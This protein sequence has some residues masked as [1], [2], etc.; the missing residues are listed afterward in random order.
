MDK[1]IINPDGTL[2]PADLFE[3][4][5]WYEGS[6][7]KFIREGGRRV[8]VTVL[9]NGVRVSTVFLA[10]DH[11]FR[12]TPL[13]F[14]SMAFSPGD[15]LDIACDRYATYAEAVEGHD[16]MVAECEVAPG[17]PPPA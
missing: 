13:W 15:G 8:A 5:A 14:E 2:R 4:A 1:A 10:I 6:G 12:G 11:G 3:W 16:R 17:T 7:D 9:P